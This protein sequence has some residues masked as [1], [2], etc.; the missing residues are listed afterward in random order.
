MRVSQPPTLSALHSAHKQY[1]VDK[2]GMAREPRHSP[3]LTT[4]VPT[5]EETVADPAWSPDGSKLLFDSTRALNGSN[6]W[7]ANGNVDI[8]VMNADGSG[9]APL[10]KLTA[11]SSGLIPSA[12]GAAWSPDGKKIAFISSVALDGSNAP[13]T[14]LNLWVMNADGSG[15]TPLSRLT[16]PFPETF[17][18]VWSP[19]GSKIAFVS[20]RALDG[21]DASILSRNIWSVRP[22][23]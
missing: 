20:D 10:T 4:C 7:N 18:P 13:N 5:I 8:C 6:G 9:L 2:A 14:A 11:G 22:D 23:G 15:A 17:G 19:D 12:F 21:S 3:N 16:A 1:L